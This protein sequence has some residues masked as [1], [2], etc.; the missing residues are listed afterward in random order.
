MRRRDRKPSL[1]EIPQNM[2]AVRVINDLSSDH[3]PITST[4]NLRYEVVENQ[5]YAYNNANWRRFSKLIY[6]NLPLV[7]VAEISNTVQVDNM[8]NTFNSTIKMAIDASVPKRRIT[9]HSKPFPNN[10][11][12]MIQIRNVYRRNWKRYRDIEDHRQMTR[13]NKS[14]TKEIAEF[15]NQSWNSMLSSLDKSS[16]PF[17]KIA[18]MLRKKSKIIPILKQNNV[19]FFTQQEKCEI[20][21]ESFKSN[22]S[23]SAHLSDTAT[24]SEV[25]TA[26]NEIQNT[27]PRP[28][29]SYFINHRKTSEIINK[30]KKL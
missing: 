29:T 11:K 26:V 13:L 2:S 8:I 20:L 30:L 5:Y 27:N 15:R 22:H 9:P 7:D 23:I 25:I 14:I 10:I 28:D 24:I 17:W 6:R 12:V 19:A 4:I 16:P 3:L 18:K 1:L 21:A